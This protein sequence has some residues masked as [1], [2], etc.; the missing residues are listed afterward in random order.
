MRALAAGV[1]LALVLV[2]CSEV[3]PFYCDAN[4]QCM[5]EGEVGT[6]VLAE[7]LCAWPDTTCPAPMLRYDE[8]AGD[9]ADVCVGDE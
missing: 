3:G 5:F 4:E 1:V 9:L 2:A 8:S 7:N 6:C